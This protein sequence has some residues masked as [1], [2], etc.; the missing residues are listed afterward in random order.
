MI[1][2]GF[3][4]MVAIAG[5][6]A[7]TTPARADDPP[8]A[9]AKQVTGLFVQSCVRFAGDKDGLRGW[10]GTTGLQVLSAGAQDR[11]LY[12]LPGVVFDA[13]NKVGKFVLVS[14]EGGSCSVVAEMASGPVVITDLEQDLHD[15][16]IS[17]KVTA[18]RADAEEK[19]LKHREYQASQGERGW[20]L[21]VSTVKDSV[22]G[23]AMLTA[24]RY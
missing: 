24:N 9:A 3:K 14:E 1:R 23:Q 22:G 17:F 16:R 18:E 7:L 8:N 10:A 2:L 20:L 19:A 4:C 21:L 12:G 6:A 11:F 15:A 13:S 5:I